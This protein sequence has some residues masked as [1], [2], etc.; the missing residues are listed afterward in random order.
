MSQQSNCLSL[1]TNLDALS[2]FD[3]EKQT[4]LLQN[5]SKTEIALQALQKEKMSLDS[6]L[7]QRKMDNERLAEEKGGIG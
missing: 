2:S 4:F 3:Q 5:P 6:A 7:E 1:M